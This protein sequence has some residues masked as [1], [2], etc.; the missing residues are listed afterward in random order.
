MADNEI[1][2]RQPVSKCTEHAC[3]GRFHW[4]L[5]LNQKRFLHV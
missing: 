5:R 3:K 2:I 4:F 1:L